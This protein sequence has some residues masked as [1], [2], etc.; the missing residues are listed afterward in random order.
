MKGLWNDTPV[1]GIPHPSGRVSND[2]FGAIALYLR[3]EMQKL[4]I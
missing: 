3:S 2:D 1:Y 4:G